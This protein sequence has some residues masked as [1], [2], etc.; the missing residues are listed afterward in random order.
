MRN[1]VFWGGFCVAS[2]LAEL[3]LRE[4][5]EKAENLLSQQEGK[6]TRKRWFIHGAPLSLFWEEH[7]NPVTSQSDSTTKRAADQRPK[8][9]VCFKAASI[10]GSELVHGAP[11]PPGR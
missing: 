4:Q 8:A 5:L 6:N 9:G 3:L 10:R 11:Q 2:G 1:P 7:L